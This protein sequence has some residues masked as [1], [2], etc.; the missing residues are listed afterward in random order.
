MTALDITARNLAKKLIN[1]SGKSLQI[2]FMGDRDYNPST[3][4]TTGD[5]STIKT[6][7]M[8]IAD[9]DLQDS[10]A[11]FASG[12]IVAGDK[13]FSIAAADIPGLVP[14]SGDKITLNGDIWT[15]E[16][17]RE[18]WSGEQIAKYDCQGRK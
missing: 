6:V 14:K 16:R 4:S 11:G 3:G 18:T 10:G 5:P 8:V 15:I 7:K 1:K 12:L 17:V 2:E 13:N 9:F